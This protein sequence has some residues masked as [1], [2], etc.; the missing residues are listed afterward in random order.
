M[1]D[2]D[3]TKRAISEGLVSAKEN[4]IRAPRCE[5]SA[6]I[7]SVAESSSYWFSRSSTYS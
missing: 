2:R 7:C 6:C 3:L 4:I 1:E 5:M